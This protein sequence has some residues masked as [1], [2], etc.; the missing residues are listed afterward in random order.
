M[1]RSFQWMDRA[2]TLRRL[3]TLVEP[4]GAVALFSS[5]HRDAPDT[6]WIAA[7]R[8]LVPSLRRG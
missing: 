8:A 1:G 5:G 4:G 6:D 7:Y 2:E 3:E